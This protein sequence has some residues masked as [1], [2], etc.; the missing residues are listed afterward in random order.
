MS[1]TDAP[2]SAI[3]KIESLRAELRRHD[4]LYFVQHNPEISDEQYDRLMAELRALEEKYPAL[5]T[6]DSPTQRVGEQPQEGFVHVRHTI[7]MR[8]IDNTYNEADLRKFDKRVRDALEDEAFGYVVEPKIDGVAVSLRYEDGLLVTAATRGDGEVGDDITA[9]ARTLRSIPL[10]L[11]GDDVPGVLEIRGEIFWPRPAFDATNAAREAAGEP[12]FANPR[13][14]TAGTLKQLDP[15]ITAIRG[16]EFTAHGYGVVETFPKDMD[17][18]SE[19][20]A[21]ARSW[22]LPVNPF[23]QRREDIDA[24]LAFV[25]NW[26]EKRHEQVYDTDGVVVKVDERSARE[27]LGYTSKAPRWCIA[28]KYAAEQAQTTLNAVTFQVGKLGTITPVA[29]LEPVL[30][31]GTTVKRATLHNFDQVARLDLHIGD[32]VTIEKA[33]EVIPQVVAVDAGKRKK[34]AEVVAPPTECPACGTPPVREEDEVYLRCPNPECPA[35]VVER[36]RYFCAR[37][38]MDID[39]A[40]A[41]F[42]ETVVSKGLVKNVADI[43]GLVEKRDE[44]LQLERMGEKSVDNLLAGIEAARTRPLARLLG[45]LTI[46]LVG[47]STAE[48]ITERYPT[49]AEIQ[50]ASAEDMQEIDG[51]GP[52]VAASLRNWL[53]SDFGS[54]TIEALRARGVNLSQPQSDEGGEKILRGKTLVVTGTL[55]RYKRSEIEAMIK[56]LGGKA[57][58]SVSKKTDYLVAG[59]NA[60]SKLEKAQKLKVPVLSEE[61]FLEMVGE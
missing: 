26:S 11:Q 47:A 28:Y 22:G 51:I 56:K 18:Y 57:T 48:L 23:V 27:A 32:R 50:A 14:A 13:N 42:V 53:D 30:L 1:P 8:S 49:I 52:E 12:A 37:D 59:E 45:S 43:F 5:V 61:E 4:F 35:Q 33:G 6:P 29:E 2:A 16:L 31:A 21:A 34:G 15:R 3:K 39:G 24:V 10:R 17:R 19:F 60:G 46:P 44:L 20:V 55:A 38:Q 58:G 25:N 41:V 40:G 36:I 9:N 54:A 7:P